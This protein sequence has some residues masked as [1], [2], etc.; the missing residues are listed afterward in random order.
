MAAAGSQ[1]AYKLGNRVMGQTDGRTDER[2]AA[3]LNAPP[4]PWGVCITVDTSR[5]N[6]TTG[7]GSD[8]VANASVCGET[9][10]TQARTSPWPVGDCVD[11]DSHCDMQPWARAAQLYRS[12]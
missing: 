4:L 11:R 7:G 3:S 5:T 10:T 8:L 1:H 9:G 12:A 2:I 6:Q